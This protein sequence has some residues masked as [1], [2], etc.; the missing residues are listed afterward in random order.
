M[1]EFNSIKYREN[2]L[3]CVIDAAPLVTHHFLSDSLTAYEI[4]DDISHSLSIQKNF[5]AILVSRQVRMLQEFGYLKFQN[6]ARIIKLCSM[7]FRIIEQLEKAIIPGRILDSICLCIG[8]I[9]YG[10][11]DLICTY[12]LLLGK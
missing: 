11:C 7:Q 10:K 4:I 1:E 5:S 9:L 12:L 3:L 6:I 8:S 2:Y